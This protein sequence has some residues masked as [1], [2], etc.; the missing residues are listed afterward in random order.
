MF[1]PALDAALADIDTVFNGFASPTETGCERCFLPE[2]T[3][4][5]RTP[6]TRVPADLL[7]RFVYK[8]PDHFE[9]HA[10]VMRR[11][12]PQ[13]ARAMADGSLSVG[14][15]GHG[16]TRV[17]WRSWPTDQADAIHTFLTAWWRQTLVT[18][19][20]PDPVRD[21]FECCASITG[22][23]T[24]FLADW[25]PH[26]VADAH[27]V[28]CVRWWLDLLVCD[29]SPFSTW[30]DDHQE[31]TAVELRTWLA[32]HAPAR[33]RAQGEPRLATEAELL[34]LPYDERWAHPYWTS[35]AST[36]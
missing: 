5:L 29:D 21:I 25:T 24:P 2:E 12:M 15:W 23:M 36:N 6:Y 19:D 22:T 9:D 7:H 13:T 3:A 1:S 10:A 20:P 34:A 35:P 28:S 11:L 32:G 31:A 33:L 16:L 30:D 26:P 14:W 27:L 17:D 18:P 8:V 4:Y